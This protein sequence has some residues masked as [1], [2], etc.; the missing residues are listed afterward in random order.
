M[1]MVIDGTYGLTYPN[2]ATNGGYING[3]TS[4]ATTS[5]TAITF[6]S[7]PS[8]AKRV[9]V[10]F[11]GVSTNSSAYYQIQIGT[12]SSVQTTGYSGLNFG[13]SSSSSYA[14]N[15]PTSSFYVANK[16]NS[17]DVFSGAVVLYNIGS[18]NYV[19]SGSLGTIASQIRGTNSNGSVS[20]SG[21]LNILTVSDSSGASFTAGS[22]NVFWE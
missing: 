3:S 9:T 1:S 8:W 6:S 12:G 4:Q 11:N 2:S 5:G 15:N 7:I 17:S 20:L 14:T 13:A 16:Y 21:S 10:L 18:N 22:I 19:L